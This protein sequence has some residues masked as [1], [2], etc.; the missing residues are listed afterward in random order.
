V[1]TPELWVN[2]RDRRRNLL[3]NDPMMLEERKCGQLE[4]D[5]SIQWFFSLDLII[6]NRAK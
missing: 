2:E 1:G 5:G 6:S 3:P 4:T